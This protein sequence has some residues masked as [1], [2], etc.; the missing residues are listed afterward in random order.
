[1]KIEKISLAE[2]GEEYEQHIKLQE[3]FIEK[4]KKDLEKAKTMGDKTAVSELE[5]RLSKFQEIKREL[6]ETAEKLKNYYKG[7]I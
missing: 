5:K 7:E 1:M 4:C 6:K 2:L 3:H